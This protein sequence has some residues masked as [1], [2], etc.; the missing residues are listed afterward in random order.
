MPSSNRT[1]LGKHNDEGESTAIGTAASP[2]LEDVATKID[3]VNIGEDRTT[4]GD[5]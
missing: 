5:R 2:T 4:G 1:R 3:Q